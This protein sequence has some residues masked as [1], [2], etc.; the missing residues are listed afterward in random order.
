MDTK[1]ATYFLSDPLTHTQKK[2]RRQKPASRFLWW[3][4][5]EVCSAHVKFVFIPGMAFKAVSEWVRISGIW[6]QAADV[7]KGEER[8]KVCAENTGERRQEQ[9]SRKW[10]P[11]SRQTEMMWALL[12][13]QIRMLG[14]F[15]QTPEF[16]GDCLENDLTWVI[17][18]SSLSPSV[19]AQLIK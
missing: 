11:E 6:V 4:N 3:N 16:I 8:L 18:K 15:W 10:L 7:K 5:W 9:E 17:E 1:S 14:D 13:E 19:A 2:K 12:N